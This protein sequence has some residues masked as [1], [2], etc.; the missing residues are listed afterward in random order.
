MVSADNRHALTLRSWNDR[1]RSS[2]LT[3]APCGRRQGLESKS[4][5][6]RR[7]RKSISLVITER[8]GSIGL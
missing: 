8:V 3:V 1:D 7:I 6:I 4:E 5:N 2:R